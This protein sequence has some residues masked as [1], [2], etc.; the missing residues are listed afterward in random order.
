M[1]SS[2]LNQRISAII[3]TYNRRDLVLRAL[4]SVYSQTIPCHEAVV[5][6]DGS[7][8]DT[9]SAIEHWRRDHE[10]L[11]LRYI[12]Q[13]NR[14]VSAA[15]NRGWQCA[16]GEWIAFLD[17]DDT[18]LPTHN[19]VLLL[20]ASFDPAANFIFGNEIS[21]RAG[22]KRP[23]GNGD[24]SP[25]L[26]GEPGVHTHRDIKDSCDT[27]VD[28]ERLLLGSFIPTSSVMARKSLF[29]R[30]GGFNETLSFGEDRLCWLECLVHSK[31]VHCALPIS[32]Y[33]VHSGNLTH[34]D[35][36]INQIHD[37]IFLTE[38]LIAKRD[39]FQISEN[40]LSLLHGRRNEL[41]REATIR[42]GL[43]AMLSVATHGFPNGRYSLKDWR[44]GCR[45]SSQKVLDKGWRRWQRTR[46]QM[47]R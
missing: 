11:P 16:Q 10:T 36:R 6:D 1:S 4:D 9:A 25:P 39:Y 28:Y 41:R 35:N 21:P 24:S 3:P 22:S 19:E 17:S 5:V 26:S 2:P 44:R 33:H 13:A 34:V 29:V 43:V 8:D 27:S 38:Y 23:F 31:T 40:T 18:W 37:E 47:I 45:F 7:D 46:A 15:R 20:A 42:Q 14:G 12:Y 32:V 30:F